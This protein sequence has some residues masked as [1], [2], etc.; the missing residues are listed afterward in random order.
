MWVGGWV[1]VMMRY[2]L[3]S[4]IVFFLLGVMVVLLLVV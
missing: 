4:F 3:S 1:G 2:I